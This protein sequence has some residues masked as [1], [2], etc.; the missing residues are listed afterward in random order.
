MGAIP[1]KNVYYLL[2]YAWDHF[3]PKGQVEVGTEQSPDLPNLLA[4]VLVAGTRRLLRRGLDRGYVGYVEE[5]VAPRGRF[6]FAESVKHS[7][8]NRGRLV[9]QFDELSA[10]VIHNR[11]LKATLATLA[12][13]DALEQAL[14]REVVEIRSRLAGVTEISPSRHLFQRLQISKSTGNYGLLMQICHLLLDLQL[15]AEGGHRSR[16]SDILSDRNRMPAIFEAFVRNFY[17]QEQEQFSV[18]SEL[19]H[20]DTGTNCSSAHEAYLPTMRTDVTLRSSNRTVVIDAK[21]Y[22]QALVS[23]LGGHLKVRSSHL[24]QLISYLKNTQK[25]RGCD[26][27]AEGLLLYPCTDGSRLRLEFALLGHRVRVCSVD[28][29]QPSPAIHKEMVSLLEGSFWTTTS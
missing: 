19:I 2:L 5:L 28:L 13:S 24:F 6:L 10:D 7:S 29:T 26:A 12:R 9:C 16:F 20:W 14:R 15:P 17:R 4:R 8:F 1:I 18:G 11:I 23:H 21:F 22:P 25:K 27:S 3:T